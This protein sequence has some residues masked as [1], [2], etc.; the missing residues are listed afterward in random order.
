M[1]EDNK[2]QK[3]S[4]ETVV[5]MN[6]CM[7]CDGDKV[8]ALNK[9]G[10][11]YSGI[12]FPGGHVE[13]GEL[14]ADAVIREVYEETGLTIKAPMLRGIYHWYRDGIHNVGLLY[15]AEEFK[16]TLKSSDEGE[17]YW[18]RKEEYAK[19]S[20]AHGMDKVLKIMDCDTFSECFMDVH[21]DGSV[22]EHIR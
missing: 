12:T 5:F 4:T 10:K 7:I 20:L 16:G 19:L 2:Q 3:H 11:N 1:N 22:T 8:L 17:V 6:M 13:K 15:R 18:I 21:E 9:V 14:F